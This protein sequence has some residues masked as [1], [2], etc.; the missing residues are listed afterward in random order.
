M[1]TK[2]EWVV[3]ND[4]MIFGKCVGGCRR[5]MGSFQIAE[6]RGWGHLQYLGQDIGFEIQK[7][8]ARRIVHCVNNFDDLVDILKVI[9]HSDLSDSFPQKMLERIEKALAAAKDT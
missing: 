6:M 3:V 5:E 7:A 1:W 9:Y 2:S 4:T 8:N